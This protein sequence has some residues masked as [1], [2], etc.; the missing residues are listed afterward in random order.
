MTHERY[1]EIAAAA[2]IGQAGPEELFELEQHVA[3]CEPC[4]QAYLDYLVLAGRQYAETSHD[5]RL[6]ARDA[7]ESLNSEL[8]TRRFLERAKREGICF[9][10]AVDEELSR[11]A[12]VS[13]P[14]PHPRAP[15]QGPRWRVPLLAAAAFLLAGAGLSVGFFYGSRAL[16]S[17]PVV[18]PDPG[19]AR[20]RAEASATAWEHLLADQVAANARLQAELRRWKV[21]SSQANERLRAAQEQLDSAARRSQALASGR[22]ASQARLTAVQRQLAASQALVAAAEQEAADERAHVASLE[23]AL[24]DH[25]LRTA[26]LQNE[27]AADSAILAQQRKL[28]GLTRDVTNLMGARDLHIVD[29]VDTDARGK[30]RRAV[31][32]IFYTKDKS[33]IFYAYDLDEAKIAKGKFQYTVWATGEANGG[34][35][36]SLGIFYTDNKTKSRWVFKC[37]NPRVLHDINSVFVT[38]EPTRSGI[39]HP[40][41][42]HLMYAYL[43]GHPNHP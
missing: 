26:D 25:R 2:S 1:G 29:V 22:T 34:R 37:D 8:L 5:P 14:A 18:W 42:Q 28:L 36:R 41:G 3:E 38:L 33:L 9:S 15:W 43:G 17:A 30:S 31:G 39:P 20:Q 4:R 27:L 40:Q 16:R 21:A 6:S 35:A 19:Q 11:L 12:P 7:Q 32:R 10:A 13:R 23:A 24:L